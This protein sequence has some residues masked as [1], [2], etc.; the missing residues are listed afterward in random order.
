MFNEILL[1]TLMGDCRSQ[2]ILDETLLLH[3]CSG[4]IVFKFHK[5]LFGPAQILADSSGLG[6]LEWAPPPSP[7]AI[8]KNASRSVWTANYQA[9]YP[10]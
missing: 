10:S 3:L 8:Q 1:C 5:D 2:R 4:S 9:T 6:Y 7:P